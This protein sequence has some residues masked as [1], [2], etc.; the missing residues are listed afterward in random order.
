MPSIQCKREQPRGSNDA[1]Q[2]DAGTCLALLPQEEDQAEPSQAGAR[3]PLQL[4]KAVWSSAASQAQLADADGRRDW[5]RGA[6]AGVLPQRRHHGHLQEDIR[7]A[8]TTAL[9]PF[10]Q[11]EQWLLMALP[12]VHD[13]YGSLVRPKED[14]VVLPHT[15]CSSLPPSVQGLS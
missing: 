11:V 15:S 14:I 4:N 13:S 8:A 1:P 7:A 2:W 6:A 3:L 5:C 12:L 9:L 10:L